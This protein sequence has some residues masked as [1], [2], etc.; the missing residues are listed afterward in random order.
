LF[1]ELFHV[2]K[3]DYRQIV[4]GLFGGSGRIEFYSEDTFSNGKNDIGGVGTVG[5]AVGLEFGGEGCA[6]FGVL[7]SAGVFADDFEEVGA[8]L[9]G[10]GA[11]DDGAAADV[12]C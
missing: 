7:V 5:F 9:L 10:A 6:D 12:G 3:V 8:E 1:H 11:H 4:S 2:V